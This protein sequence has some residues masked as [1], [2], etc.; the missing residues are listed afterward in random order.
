M[1]SVTVNVPSRLATSM[2]L[3]SV[4]TS[5]R[6]VSLCRSTEIGPACADIP[7]DVRTLAVPF[8]IENPSLWYW[9]EEFGSTTSE[10][11]LLGAFLR[12]PIIGFVAVMFGVSCLVLLVACV[13]LASMLLARGGDKRKETAI[14]LA[15]GAG[16]GVLIRQQ[17]TENLMVALAGGLGGALLALWI[18]SALAA[19][20]PPVDVPLVVSANV[21]LRVFLFALLV[22]SVTAL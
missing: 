18:T 7:L 5:N 8:R 21:D 1:P 12:N 2:V 16:R 19:W 15:L 13:N 3:P 6:A 14:R 20:R 4:L 17:L 9:T 11:G 10:P 22:S